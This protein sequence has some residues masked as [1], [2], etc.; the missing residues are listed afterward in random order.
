M[1]KSFKKKIEQFCS[2][3]KQ[4]ILFVFPAPDLKIRKF[5]TAQ[6]NKTWSSVYT[7]SLDKRNGGFM[8]KVCVFPGTRG[9]NFYSC[10]L[11]I[12]HC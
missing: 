10:C 11:V 3:F 5:K 6:D 7:D 4:K 1:E 8:R 9:F 2:N 12:Y